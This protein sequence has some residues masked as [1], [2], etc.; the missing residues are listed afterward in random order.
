MQAKVP[1]HARSRLRDPDSIQGFL[2]ELCRSSF[3]LSRF[4]RLLLFLRHAYSHK[5]VQQNHQKTFGPLV[6]G[7]ASQVAAMAISTTWD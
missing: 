1:P 7:V 6:K 4:Q 2:S 5:R 3:P